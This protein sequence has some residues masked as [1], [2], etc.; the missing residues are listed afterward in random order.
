MKNFYY[1][2]IGLSLL[3]S[4]CTDDKAVIEI[5]LN[6][7][8]L[9]LAEG[10]SE[11]LV[12]SFNPSGTN[13]VAHSWKS[14]DMSI[15][16]VDETGMVTGAK[17]GSTVVTAIALNGGNTATC[18]VTVLKKII[19]VSDLSLNVEDT[20]M[21]VEDEL[22]LEA[23]VCPEDATD[24]TVN[25]SSSDEEVATISSEGVVTAHKVGKVTVTASTNNGDYKAMANIEI[26]ESPIY[27]SSAEFSEIGST[28]VDI[29]GQITIIWSDYNEIGICYSTEH[30][31][32]IEDKTMWLY[33]TS[34]NRS[35]T[36]LHSNTTY[37]IRFYVRK[38]DMVYYS[39]ESTVTTK[40][41]VEFSVPEI[42]HLSINSAVVSGLIDMDY[43]S[44]EKGLCYST[45]PNVTIEDG[46]IIKLEENDFLHKIENLQS[47]TTYYLKMYAVVDGTTY[48]GDE[49]SFTTK[50]G[51]VVMPTSIQLT[52]I[53]IRVE[54]DEEA[55]NSI[56]GVCYSKSPNPTINDMTMKKIIGKE[57]MATDLS[58]G[59]DYY[60]RAYSTINGITTYHEEIKIQ[61]IAK[62][63]DKEFGIT[64]SFA[65]M[66][67]LGGVPQTIYQI[68]YNIEEKGVYD[69]EILLFGGSKCGDSISGG[70]SNGQTILSGKGTFFLWIEC[71]SKW[72]TTRPRAL[73]FINRTTGIKYSYEDG[74]LIE[75][76]F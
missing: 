26:V 60:V 75:L 54:G 30:H 1:Y 28:Y 38:G 34:V 2:L 53:I 74:E 12:A 64:H 9:T 52:A 17:E 27:T 31:P 15:A 37:Y 56:S 59:T 65:G 8:E 23:I 51:V 57:Y 71:D 45:S 73:L 20:T 61:T 25:W 29:K 22:Q 63:L 24:K 18:K 33:S 21:L 5:S 36:A 50:S 47:G 6:K 46:E 68:N 40:Y 70:D 43:S 55:L 7:T 39:R 44:A 42:I 76:N 41:L 14:D 66:L 69:V 32:T 10:T 35:I 11:R 3:L 13:L 62:T 49:F 4:S 67:S 72:T 19:G 48:Y 58:N 16:S